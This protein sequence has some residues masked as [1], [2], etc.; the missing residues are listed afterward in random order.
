MATMLATPA[1]TFPNLYLPRD[2]T[3]AFGA[4]AA[5]EHFEGMKRSSCGGVPSDNYCFGLKMQRK[6]TWLVEV[7]TGCGKRAAGR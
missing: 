2:L 4:K 7:S 5:R 6:P 3:R 1:K